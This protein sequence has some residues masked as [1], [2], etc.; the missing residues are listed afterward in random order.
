[1]IVFVLSQT[2]G[3]LMAVRAFDTYSSKDEGQELKKFF[4]LLQEGR[5]VCLAVKAS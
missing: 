1:M 2:T 3:S 4:G 5:I